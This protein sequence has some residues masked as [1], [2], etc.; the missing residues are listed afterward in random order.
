M[1]LR[2]QQVESMKCSN[3]ISEVQ[4]YVWLNN[5]RLKDFFFKFINSF[6]FSAELDKPIESETKS[7]AKIKV[8]CMF[9][10]SQ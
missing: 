6:V 2:S 3:E 4:G 9:Y 1:R 8:A 10:L 7:D 5:Y